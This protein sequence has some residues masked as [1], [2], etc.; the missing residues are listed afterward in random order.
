MLQ[1][2]PTRKFNKN[3]FSYFNKKIAII[4]WQ[5]SHRTTILTS[6]NND[7]SFLSIFPLIYNKKKSFYQPNYVFVDDIKGKRKLELIDFIFIANQSSININ[8]SREITINFTI[9]PKP[10]IC[11]I[12]VNENT[13]LA[14]IKSVILLEGSRW[15]KMKPFW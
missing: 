7:K 8:S 12:K 2:F 11:V 3:S 4:P 13:T 6:M 1:N 15:W 5:I 10:K 9:D 14:S